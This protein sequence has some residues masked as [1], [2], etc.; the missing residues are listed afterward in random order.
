MIEIAVQEAGKVGECWA[1][2]SR[3][4]NLFEISPWIDAARVPV[5]EYELRAI[6]HQL[7]VGQCHVRCGLYGEAVESDAATFGT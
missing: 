2:L 7:D 6:T 3:F 4:G 5:A 1:E